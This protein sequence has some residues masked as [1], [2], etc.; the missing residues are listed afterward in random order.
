MTSCLLFFSSTFATPKSSS[1]TVRC[2]LIWLRASSVILSMPSS[3][4]DSARNSHSL[5]HV[6][7]RLRCEKSCDISAEQ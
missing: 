3:F 1:V 2:S 6:E 4:S 7:W 5:R